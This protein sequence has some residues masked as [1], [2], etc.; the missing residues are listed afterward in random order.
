MLAHPDL[1]TDAPHP[2]FG[3]RAIGVWPN[4][5][6]KPRAPAHKHTM[7]DI[8]QGID[9]AAVT[10][11]NWIQ[12]YNNGTR[13]GMPQYVSA[14]MALLDNAH[15]TLVLV[16]NALVTAKG[17]DSETLPRQPPM[18]EWAQR[19]PKVPRATAGQ[20]RDLM[21]DY[22]LVERDIVEAFNFDEDNKQY[23][24]RTLGNDGVRWMLL[25]LMADDMRPAL[26]VRER[27]AD[28]PFTAWEQGTTKVARRRV[29]DYPPLEPVAAWPVSRKYMRQWAA[30]QIGTHPE[31]VA[32]AYVNAAPGEAPPPAY[33][34][35]SYKQRKDWE[36]WKYLRRAHP[37]L[38][39]HANGIASNVVEFLG[40]PDE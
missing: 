20:V 13:L 9:R 5:R 38:V 2:Y 6:G 25:R 21:A 16:A 3:L 4:G 40:Q 17:A 11:A 30:A 34:T 22:G 19:L 24:V 31:M 23:S 29:A 10:L 27:M 36:R 35:W 14:Y 15:P 39:R 37:E 28:D 26:Y 18:W 8:A 33:R 7:G 1:I 32:A 12:A